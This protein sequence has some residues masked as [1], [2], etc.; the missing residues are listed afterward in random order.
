MAEGVRER[1][2]LVT[3]PDG[4]QIILGADKECDV[5]VTLYPGEFNAFP[6]RG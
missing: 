6:E 3:L 5:R 2:A 4:A 1:I